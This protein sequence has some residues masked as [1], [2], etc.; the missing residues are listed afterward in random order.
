M[1]T[2]KF[3][4]VGIQGLWLLQ[5]GGFL[6]WVGVLIAYCFSAH[7]ATGWLREGWA[8]IITLH[9]LELFIVAGEAIKFEGKTWQYSTIVIANA[10]VTVALA[11][12]FHIIAATSYV[13]QNPTKSPYANDNLTIT[14]AAAI[15]LGTIANSMMVAVLWSYFHRSVKIDSIVATKARTY[16]KYT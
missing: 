11:V 1:I 12:S 3:K 16:L 8:V 6:L 7:Y 2:D 5:G 15:V 14:S 9:A 4:A 10:L 13:I